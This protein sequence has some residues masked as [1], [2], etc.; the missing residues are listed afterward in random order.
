MLD[1]AQTLT[2]PH[3]GAGLEFLMTM[4]RVRRR[5]GIEPQTIALSAV[6][7][8]SGG[9]ERWL[10]GR[11]LSHP[12]RPVPLDEGVMAADGSFRWLPSD[13]AEEQT[14]PMITPI[15]RKG[16]SQD[17]IIPLVGEL[18]DRGE[19]V[20]VFRNVKGATVGAARYLAGALA[21]APADS[22]IAALP[23]GDPSV[24]S[25]ALREVLA[26]GV[27]F[28]NADLDRAERL[29]L[30]AAFRAGEL[31][32]LVAT[33]TL[34]MGVNTPAST[35]IIAELAWWDG[36][37]YTVA[38]YKN[39]VGRAGRLGYAERGRSVIIA[40]SPRAAAGAWERYVLGTPEDLHS[41]FL[42]SDPRAL[43]LRTLAGAAAA[44][45]AG[46]MNA[47]EVIAFLEDSWGAFQRRAAGD[48]SWDRGDLERRVVELERLEMIARDDQGRLELLPL[49]RFAGE[50]G[51]EVESIVRLA[52]AARAS[53]A[54]T[55]AASLL[56]LVQ[57][58][59]ELDN[60][61]LAVNSK[62]W[63]KEQSSAFAELERRGASRA[64]LESLRRGAGNVEVAKRAKRALGALL[65]V[66]GVPRV[67]IEALLMRH[68]RD[69]AV[70]GAVQGT[71]NRTVDLLPTS[72]RV[73]ELV[74]GENL[75]EAEAELMLRLQLGIPAEMTPLGV[76][77]GER[78][79]R[80]Q[81]LALHEASIHSPADLGDAD[82]ARLASILGVEPDRLSAL[83]NN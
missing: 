38:T 66:N 15:Y 27:G 20:I 81:Y 36:K 69:K 35:V 17:W 51:V 34:A 8:D 29:A 31:K 9:L 62:G 55:D 76:I 40:P 4:L 22:A 80:T 12:E 72:L 24:T 46:A 43:I 18:V 10:G 11:L 33:S 21:L 67:E 53:G 37:P 14:E 49:G 57:L 58:T 23:P 39:M 19:Q 45:E 56:S 47:E 64:I 65:W 77:Y 44:G 52:S 7:G 73:V 70:A 25:G 54:F 13:S 83:L 82:E 75:D 71:V 28:H 41:R 60:V 30:E 26:A 79:S 48:W 78:L 5:A 61:H 3:R 74:C 68:H 59:V 1:E 32:V 16:S 2:D 6:I 42:A 50:A 63:R